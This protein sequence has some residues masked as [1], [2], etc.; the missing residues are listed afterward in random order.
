MH[1]DRP[2]S[3]APTTTETTMTEKQAERYTDE[4]LN[5]KISFSQEML[6]CCETPTARD[7]RLLRD[8]DAMRT[9][10]AKRYS[11]ALNAPK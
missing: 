1:S 6:S 11:A 4:Q 9:V 2:K 8:M 10:L 7:R 3:I 5:Q